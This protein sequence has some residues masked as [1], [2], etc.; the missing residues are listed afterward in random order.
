[1]ALGIQ[2]ETHVLFFA[3]IS[4]ATQDKQ[5]RFIIFRL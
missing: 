1:M 5:T 3:F 2:R 4:V